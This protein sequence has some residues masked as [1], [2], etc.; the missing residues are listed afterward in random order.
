MKSTIIAFTIVLF[1]HIHVVNACT[2]IS[3]GNDCNGTLLSVNEYDN[4]QLL[5]IP[6]NYQCN[7][8]QVCGTFSPCDGASCYC[9]KSASGQGFGF[10]ANTG[11]SCN[12]FTQCGSGNTCPGTDECWVDQCC[13]Y[14]V[15]VPHSRMCSHCG[16]T[17]FTP[18]CSLAATVFDV[19]EE[20][21]NDVSY[22]PVRSDGTSISGAQCYEG[23][24]HHRRVGYGPNREGYQVKVFDS[25]DCSGQGSLLSCERHDYGTI[26]DAYFG[27]CSNDGTTLTIDLSGTPVESVV[28]EGTG[29][30][31]EQP[32]GN[33]HIILN[34]PVDYFELYADNTCSFANGFVGDQIFPSGSCTC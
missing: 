27:S 33:G 26:P 13:G 11:S 3:G 22:K 4:R 5:S 7:D 12:S 9:G 16:G 20:N 14:P 10:N 23:G 30:G 19:S 34:C 31:C 8:V 28:A 15:C 1:G 25:Q 18:T 32:N 29:W 17:P 24:E 21:G 6:S 2:A